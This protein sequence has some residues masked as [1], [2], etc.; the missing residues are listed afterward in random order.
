[1]PEKRSVRI[2]FE[3]RQE[4]GGQRLQL[5]GELYR[6]RAGWTLVYREPPDESGAAAANTLVIE[7]GE[8]RL[9]RRGQMRLEQRFRLGEA[10]AGELETPYGRHEVKAFTSSLTV[11]LE[12]F[13]GTVEW[14]YELRMQ[15]QP[16][17]SF[18]IRLDI[19][20]A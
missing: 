3:S 15:D 17:G 2:G 1:M 20:E 7:G 14:E 12:E 18:G 11:R 13:S 6:M 9:R 4:D 16:V 10:L 8:L 5:E 19:Q